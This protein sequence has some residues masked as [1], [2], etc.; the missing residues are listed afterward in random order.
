[1]TVLRA[2]QLLGAILPKGVLNVVTGDGPLTGEALVRHPD[3]AKVTFT[4]SVESGRRVNKN[5]AE[6]IIPVTLE[7]GGKSPLI[8]YPDAD[9]DRA[10]QDVVTG[11][12]FTRQGQSCSASSRVFVHEALHDAF[13]QCVKQLLEKMVIGDPLDSNTDIGTLISGRQFDKVQSFL[14]LA[15]ADPKLQIHQVGHLPENTPGLFL[16]PTLISGISNDHPLCQ[17]EIFGP[18]MCVLSWNNEHDVIEQAN[19]TEYGLAAGV[20]TKDISKALQT[21]KKLNAGFVQVNQYMVFRPSLAFGG[22]KHS[23]L[24]KEASENAMIEHFTKEKL[25]L[26]NCT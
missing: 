14:K 21:V 2:A 19:A 4:G 22:F 5:A 11:M 13:I 8:I 6:K 25:I 20:W 3:I 12:R 7:L 26:I 17:Q 18:V 9:L 24:G 10:V 1:M 16:L 15:K 23:G